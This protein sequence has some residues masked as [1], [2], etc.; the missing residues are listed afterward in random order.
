[1]RWKGSGA[2]SGVVRSVPSSSKNKPTQM[3]ATTDQF[4]RRFSGRFFSSILAMNV[5]HHLV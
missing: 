4:S 5:I 3:K 1:M 2:Q